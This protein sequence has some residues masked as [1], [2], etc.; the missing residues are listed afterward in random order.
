MVSPAANTP[1]GSNARTIIRQTAMLTK[2]F[3]ERFILFPPV[4]KFDAEYIRLMDAPA[5]QK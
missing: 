4:N 3:V 2:R 5:P 1:M